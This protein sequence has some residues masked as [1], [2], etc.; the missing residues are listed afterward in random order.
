M[1]SKKMKK[2]RIV[3]GKHKGAVLSV[4]DDQVKPTPDRVR[5]TLFN[6]LSPHIEKS[7]VLD[8]FGG[9]GCLSFE[10]VSRGSDSALYV[11]SSKKACGAFKDSLLRYRINDIR[12]L[13]RDSFQMIQ[14]ENTQGRFNII[15]VD[16][17]YGKFELNQ[18][19]EKLFEKNWANDDSL[20]YLESNRCLKQLASTK[21]Q[22]VKDSTAGN[23]Y[24]GI[25]KSTSAKSE[26]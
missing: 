19:I 20:I 16:P 17:P 2:V 8:L 23:V 10:S 4:E 22:L 15:F 26:K 11:D 3:G 21:Y 9:S 25:L 12:L 13:C 5:E 6:W 7:K 14:E 24:Y 18:I 1:T